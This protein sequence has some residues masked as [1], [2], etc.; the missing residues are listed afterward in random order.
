[1]GRP[2]ADAIGQAFKVIEDEEPTMTLEASPQEA[3]AR[4]LNGYWIAKAIYAAVKLDLP[5]LLKDG[6][7]TPE[8]LAQTVKVQPRALYRLLRALASVGIFA[9]NDQ[10]QFGMSPM[11][12]CLCKE[13]PGGQ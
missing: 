3:I 4:M 7:K 13:A 1:M 9:E 12:D 8:V 6:P 2:F 5:D 11:S 10:R